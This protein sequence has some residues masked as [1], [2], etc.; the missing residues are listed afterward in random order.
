[1]IQEN[2]DICSKVL[3][4]A[5]NSQ[6]KEGRTQVY[7]ME[8]TLPDTFRI[9][10]HW[11]YSQK[12][13]H[14]HYEEYYDS[15]IEDEDGQIYANKCSLETQT[16]IKLWV[17][18]EKLLVPRLQNE[19]MELLGLI[20][21]TCTTPFEI[22]VEYIYANTADSSPLRL[23]VV[24]LIAWTAPS[25]EYKK[26]PHLYPYGFLLDLATVFSAAVPRR[27][28]ANKRDRLDITDYYIE[29]SAS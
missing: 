8:D 11:L 16:R 9:F 21:Q 25:R 17:L 27:A 23:F 2:V 5:F 7:V 24:N 10:V 19:V 29:D 26:Y 20:S 4:K 6:F 28:A 3:E 18:A 14:I 13:T 22:C 12:L 1:M 15:N